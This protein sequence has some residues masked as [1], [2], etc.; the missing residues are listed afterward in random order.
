VREGHAGGVSNRGA[1]WAAPLGASATVLGILL[2]PG[3]VAARTASDTGPGPGPDQGKQLPLPAPGPD[4]RRVFP[5]PLRISG[6]QAAG[7]ELTLFYQ[8]APRAD[9]STQVRSR[10]VRETDGAVAVLLARPPLSR[11]SLRCNVRRQ[12]GSVSIRRSRPLE[13]RVLVDLAQRGALVTPTN[14]RP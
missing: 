4:V 7:R 9:C 3:L 6:Y 8:V 13:G 5:G 14:G 11:P 12:S 1:R 2:L 10:R